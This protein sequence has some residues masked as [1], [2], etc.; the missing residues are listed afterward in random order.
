MQWVS[1]LLMGQAQWVIVNEL[2]QTEF[3]NQKSE[4]IH[5]LQSFI[6]VQKRYFKY[7]L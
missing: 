1:N 4:Y 3:I 7:L 2:H 6:P 5:Y